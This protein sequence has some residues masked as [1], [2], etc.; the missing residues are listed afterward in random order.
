MKNMTEILSNA[1]I[2]AVL[3]V[4][5]KN[6]AVDLANALLDGGINSVE[7]TLRTPNAIECVRE[8]VKK[9]P[10]L[11][12]GVGTVLTVDQVR[13]VADSGALFAVS[14]GCNPRIIDAANQLNLPFAPGIMTPSDIEQALEHGCKAMK[15]FPAATSGG[16]KHL[17]SMAA[18]YKHLGIGFIPLG[19]L[20]LDNMADYFK[21]PLVLA[22]G[23]SWLATADLIKAR[24]W[25]QIRKN[26]ED[27]MNALP[28]NA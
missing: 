3:A 26:A 27:A 24:A 1:K 9:V 18:P 10:Q 20:K 6:D 14:P 25:S 23:G 22:I 11:N 5:D 4:N 19:G 13:Q 17:E 12:V 21:S 7:M 16:L 15:F 8:V 28:K 2:V